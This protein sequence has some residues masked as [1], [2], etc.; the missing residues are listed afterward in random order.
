LGDGY[1][2]NDVLKKIATEYPNINPNLQRVFIGRFVLGT[3]GFYILH[4]YGG[5]LVNDYYSYCTGIM[6]GLNVRYIFGT[7]SGTP[8]RKT[9]NET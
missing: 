9:I 5:T 3:S 2:S 4:S 7:T 6:I 8:Y 1:S